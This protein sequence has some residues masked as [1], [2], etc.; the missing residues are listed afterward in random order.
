MTTVEQNNSDGWRRRV[1]RQGE[2]AVGWLA[3]EVLDNDAVHVAVK[4]VVDA[5]QRVFRARESVFGVL[6]L[7]SA[8]D[9][10][11]LTRRLRSVS[12]RL[13]DVE[14]G[15]D[16]LSQKIGG[17]S[18]SDVA[19]RLNGMESKLDEITKSQSGE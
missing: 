2:E 17:M 12:Q 3:Q 7:S 13:E 19:A 4:G 14:D 11:K 5:G 1:T 8:S 15:V 10:Q 18:K 6:D 9:L 16:G